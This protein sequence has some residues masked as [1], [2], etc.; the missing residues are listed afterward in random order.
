MV[1][2]VPGLYSCCKAGN[3]KLVILPSLA[4]VSAGTLKSGPCLPA[5]SYLGRGILL[6]GLGLGSVRVSRP[7]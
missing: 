2:S 3:Y 7:C 1:L 6:A 4:T 5:F